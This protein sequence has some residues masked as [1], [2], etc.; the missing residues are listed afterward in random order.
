MKRQIATALFATVLAAGPVIAQVYKCP[1][2]DGS[3]QYRDTPCDTDAHSLRKLD[4]PPAPAESPAARMDKT[5]R[6][7]DALHD[8]RQLKQRQAEEAQAAQAQR[9]SRCNHARDH[10]RNMER[11]G[12]VYR[13]D[14]AGNREYL[15]DAQRAQAVEQARASVQQWC[16]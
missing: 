8:E 9:Q 1:G 16:D 6:L 7:L 13:L 11:A 5:R 12:R 2:A 4:T 14:A 10:L 3:V 15:P